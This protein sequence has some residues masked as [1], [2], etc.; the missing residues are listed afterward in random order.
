MLCRWSHSRRSGS[1]HF[2]R[3]HLNRLRS[4]QRWSSSFDC[5]ASWRAHDGIVLSSVV[6]RSPDRKSYCLI[7]GANDGF[8]KV[9][10]S[11]LTACKCLPANPQVWAISNDDNL[12]QLPEVSALMSDSDDAHGMSRSDLCLPKHSLL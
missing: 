5:T 7:T 9:S 10:Q 6:S 11:L 8:V 1:L 12:S 4:L 3:R 2:F